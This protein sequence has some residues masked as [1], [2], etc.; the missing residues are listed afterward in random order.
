MLRI[1]KHPSK[2]VILTKAKL[3]LIHEKHTYYLHSTQVGTTPALSFRAKKIL[4]MVYLQKFIVKRK[5]SRARWWP[6]G[7]RPSQG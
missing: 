2:Q 5:A 3:S 6:R 7:V 1:K 4:T